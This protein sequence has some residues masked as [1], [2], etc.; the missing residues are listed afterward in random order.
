M[1]LPSQHFLQTIDLSNLRPLVKD[2]QVVISDAGVKDCI[3]VYGPTGFK[4][5]FRSFQK[6]DG[7]GETIHYSIGFWFLSQ[8][9]SDE[10]DDVLYTAKPREQSADGMQTMPSEWGRLQ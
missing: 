5:G 4:N 9:Y 1:K 8:D 10:F 7:H 3:G 6:L 2:P